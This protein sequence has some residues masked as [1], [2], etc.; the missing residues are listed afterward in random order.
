MPA[1]KVSAKH[2]NYGKAGQAKESFVVALLFLLDCIWFLMSNCV[3]ADEKWCRRNNII[4]WTYNPLETLHWICIQDSSRSHFSRKWWTI[5]S[6]WTLAMHINEKIWEWYLFSVKRHVKE[7]KRTKTTSLSV[8]VRTCTHRIY[9]FFKFVGKNSWLFFKF[10]I[11][12]TFS[13][14]LPEITKKNKYKT[15]SFIPNHHTVDG[16]TEKKWTALMTCE[17]LFLDPRIQ[18]IVLMECWTIETVRGHTM[19]NTKMRKNKKE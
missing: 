17:L 12:R 2:Q 10:E 15:L 5:H 8:W 14:T 6:L 7:K 3:R 18:C 13:V 9:R 16:K 11:P 4:K 19:K 1:Q